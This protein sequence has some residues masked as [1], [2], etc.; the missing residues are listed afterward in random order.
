[1]GGMV[2]EQDE[3]ATYMNPVK[4]MTSDSKKARGV[5]SANFVVCLNLFPA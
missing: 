5:L 4:F 3:K 1:M 2:D